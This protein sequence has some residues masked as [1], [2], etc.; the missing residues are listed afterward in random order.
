MRI[1][2]EP[3]GN[4]TIFQI[5]NESGMYMP[6][7]CGGRGACGKCRVKITDGY[8]PPTLSDKNAFSDNELREGLRLACRC[9]PEEEIYIEV[10]EN[11]EEESDVLSIS[12][13]YDR[14]EVSKTII[15]IDIGT[16][17]IAMALADMIT[18]KVIDEYSAINKQ[19]IY[20]ADVISRIQAALDGRG[21]ELRE[22][23]RR[24]LWKG[25]L[26][27]CTKN[28]II[29]EMINVAANTTMIHLLMGY[30]CDT[31]GVAPFTPYSTDEVCE[32]VRTVF[33]TYDSGGMQVLYDVPVR[34]LPGISTYVGADIVADMLV[35]GLAD[36]DKV[37][38]LL[39]LGT[40]AEMAIGNKERIL[41]ASAAAGPAFEGGNITHGTGSVPGA[42][43]GIEILN[44][45]HIRLKTI[46]DKPAAGICGTGVVEIAY[47][48]LKAG[49]IDETGYMN[50]VKDEFVLAK[51]EAGGNV[52]F[53]KKD[54]REL[55][56][57]KAAVRAGLETLLIRY[58]IA[59]EEIDTVYLAGGFGYNINPAKAAGI[60]MIPPAFADKIKPV[61]NGALEG[62][63]LCGRR[64][65]EKY[66]KEMLKQIRKQT[67][68]ITLAM[69]ADFNELYI[70]HMFF[71]N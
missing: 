65:A 40:N 69:D 41:V 44:N 50:T 71:D 25:I 27:L 39:D 32:T 55:Q 22:C 47:E 57:A 68:E 63:I 51:R 62:A 67:L 17:T 61:G 48:L 18:G 45:N 20:G 24:D 70:K 19:R 42:V 1:K 9:V 35:C 49:V 5:L 60:G 21:A 36:T 59:A 58:G 43:C 2:I 28:R 34:I 10:F 6:A 15:G 14:C 8:A 3:D 54:V 7:P 11:N 56:L 29:P 23:I 12:G 64:D 38:V 4:K 26:K 66:C 30:P 33:G 52:S 13:T 53:F 37:N 16:T 46:Q 31:L